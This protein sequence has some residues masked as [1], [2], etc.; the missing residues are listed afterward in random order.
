[1]SPFGVNLSVQDVFDGRAQRLGGHR[2]RQHGDVVRQAHRPDRR[3]IQ[4]ADDD[5]GHL[6]VRLAGTQC[7]DH[8]QAVHARH[9]E[10]ADEQ[11]RPRLA[12]ADQ[13]LEAVAGK[14]ADKDVV[15]GVRPEQIGTEPK[16]D[17]S[18]TPVTLVVEIAEPM[19]SESIVYL[20]IGSGSII[21]RI[22][23]D[24]IFHLG[25]QVDAQFELD[26]VTLFD[27]KTEDVL[28]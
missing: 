3:G 28:K 22:Q 1:M 25:E 10:V 6:P 2:L 14:Y 20:K 8:A 4:S 11:V 16:T 23:G 17:G 5:D 12:D 9:A 15:F 26:K 18:S 24:H 7:A 19:G 13:R 21:A 27:P